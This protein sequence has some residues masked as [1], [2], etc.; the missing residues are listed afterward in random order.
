[1]YFGSLQ[2]TPYRWLDVCALAK[3][4]CREQNPACELV[5]IKYFTADVRAKFSSRGEVSYRAQ[6][7]YLLS[8]QA[9]AKK[10]NARLEVTRG[11]YAVQPKKFYAH[12]D[13]VDFNLKLAVWAPEEKQTDVSI[14]VHM[15]CDAMDQ[16][17]DQAVVFSNDSDLAPALRA[18]KLRWRGLKVGVVAPVRGAE[19]NA[20][21]DLCEHADWTRTGISDEELAATQLPARVR[22]R[23]RVIAKPGHW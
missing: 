21:A 4:L 5:C 7:D 9:H 15:I 11:K 3:R 8:L 14:A 13:P 1:M 19:R 12:Q 10:N 23:K 22:T 17:S 18:I 6:Q 16:S 20:S 2:G